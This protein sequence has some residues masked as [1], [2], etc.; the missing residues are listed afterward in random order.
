MN[1]KTETHEHKSPQC[2]PADEGKICQESACGAGWITRHGV[3]VEFIAKSDA[4]AAGYDGIDA[5]FRAPLRHQLGIKPRLYLNRIRPCVGRSTT[6][7]KST[8]GGNAGTGRQS[9]CSGR[10]VLNRSSPGSCVR[11]III[12]P[13]NRRSC[14]TMVPQSTTAATRSLWACSR[15]SIRR[16]PSSQFGDPRLLDRAGVIGRKALDRMHLLADDL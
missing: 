15:T 13:C 2:K 12:A 7:A 5:I 10:I 8:P 6:T 14:L 3:A 1:T 4:K 9:I 16:L 11:V